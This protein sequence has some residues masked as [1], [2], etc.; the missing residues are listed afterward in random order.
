MSLFNRD[1]SDDSKPKASSSQPGQLP[2]EIMGLFQGMMP[3]VIPNESSPNSIFGLNNVSKLSS[4]EN[5]TSE[6][7]PFKLLK[8]LQP[9]ITENL[10]REI[11]TVYEFHIKSQK[12]QNKYEEEKF[13]IFFLDLK[14]LPSG[15]MGVGPC[16]LSKVDCVIKLSDEDLNDLLTDNLKPF[17][18]YMSGRIE[19]EG[20]LQDVFK[21]KKLIKNVTSA[22]GTTK[23]I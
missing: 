22:L 3:T 18:A 1:S 20:D 8:L 21:L 19:I 17:T 11:Q 13:E 2:S 16:L 10:I 4:A 23:I 5:D 7:L 6:N 14:T 15:N 12:N 9:L